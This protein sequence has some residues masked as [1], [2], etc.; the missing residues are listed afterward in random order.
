MKSLYIKN[1]YWVGIF[2]GMLVIALMGSRTVYSQGQQNADD[3]VYGQQS[4]YDGDYYDNG[5]E[6]EITFNSFY[7]ALSPYG[8]WIDYGSYGQVWVCSDPNFRPY[9]TNGSWV[10]TNLGWSWNS[11]YSWGWAP[12]HYGRW[13]FASN[14]GWYWVPGYEWAPAWVYWGNAANN[15]AWAPVSPG[16]GLSI[17]VAIGSIPVSFWT[18]LPGRYMGYSNMHRYYVPANRNNVYIHNTTIINNYN[19]VNNNVRFARGPRTEDVRRFTG[20]PVNTVR[21]VRSNNAA[22][23][24]RVSNGR[25][26]VYRPGRNATNGNNP[27]NNRGNS[28]FGRNNPNNNTGR[29]NLNGSTN[30]RSDNNRASVGSR[31]TTNGNEGYNNPNR[32]RRTENNNAT[33]RQ[34]ATTTD[35][36]NMPVNNRPATNNSSNNST[37]TRWG[38]GTNN[39]ANTTRPTTNNNAPVRQNVTQQKVKTTLPTSVDHSNSGQRVQ[40]TTTPATN[41]VETPKTNTKNFSGGKFDR[42]NRKP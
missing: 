27:N 29:N 24:G 21:V 18:Y 15:Y 38:R 31:T 4:G 1:K 11:G 13:G 9:Y 12:F 35:K 8:R 22:D 36:Q 26:S 42:G 28:N 34:P 23:N 39:P 14:I 19:I 3:M 7:S 5:S 10:S 17:N 37:P 20:R 32:N 16:M 30:N 33:P 25:M 2:S 40:R 41:H 6:S